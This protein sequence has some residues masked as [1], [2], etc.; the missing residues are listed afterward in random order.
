M[1]FNTKE[2]I[3]GLQCLGLDLETGKSTEILVKELEDLTG[4]R[5]VSNGSRI[6]RRDCVTFSKFK[7]QISYGVNGE[8]IS[9]KLP[10]NNTIAVKTIPMTKNNYDKFIAHKDLDLS[11]NLNLSVVSA[12]AEIKALEICTNYVLRCK[13]PHFNAMYKYLLCENCEYIDTKVQ[14]TRFEDNIRFMEI[15][16]PDIIEGAMSGQFV[17]NDIAKLFENSIGSIYTN[18]IPYK[19]Y[20]DIDPKF[21]NFVKFVRVLPADYFDNP[22]EHLTLKGM[23][24]PGDKKSFPNGGFE[25]YHDNGTISSIGNYSNGYQVGEWK[26]YQANGELREVESFYN[27][28]KNGECIQQI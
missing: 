7:Y 5:Q 13:S 21:K 10:N 18:Y 12:I 17:F 26:R 9:M 8:V 20:E 14:E 4:I 22:D 16:S 1:N 25:V 11:K 2:T 3:I 27:I 24:M 6:I 15:N 19:V 28:N 23:Y